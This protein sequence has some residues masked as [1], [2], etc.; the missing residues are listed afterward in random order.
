MPSFRSTLESVRLLYRGYRGYTGSI[1][2]LALL[3][4]ISGLLEAVGI[5]AFIPA[6]AFLTGTEGGSDIITGFIKDSFSFLNV[7]YSFR[8]LG[9]FAVILFFVRTLAL[10]WGNYI[11]AVITA[12]YE[13]R[14]REALFSKTIRS[15]WSYLLEQKIGHLQTILTTH[16]SFGQ[17]TLSMLG[18]GIILFM[19]VVAYM[20][21]AINISLSMSLMTLAAACVLSALISPLLSYTRRL[22]SGMEDISRDLSHFVNENVAGMKTVK[23]MHAEEPVLR[24]SNALFRS[25]RDLKI[26]ITLLNVLP[27]SLMQ[28]LGFLFVMALFYLSYKSGRFSLPSFMATVYLLQRI[29]LY[30]QQIQ[31]N[32]LSIS[33][34]NTYLRKLLAQEAEVARYEEERSGA[35]FSFE[36][37]LRFE[38]VHFSY[39]NRPEVLTG[40]SFSL[41]KSEM[42]GLIGPSG[43]G[44]TTVSDLLLR[45]FSPAQGLITLDGVPLHSLALPAW[46]KKVGYV[47]QDIF[48]LND[49]IAN[50]IRFYD[51][52]LTEKDLIAAAR[53]ANAVEFIDALPHGMETVIGEK[54]VTLSQGQR[55]R[56]VIARVLARKPQILIL[57]EA[58]SAL[59]NKSEAIIQEV[60][61]SLKSR[62]TILVIAHR[63]STVLNT[64][65]LLI[66]SD[67]VITEEGSPQE[68]LNDKD[69]YFFKN[70][71]K[72]F[73]TSHERAP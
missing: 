52:T 50:N 23:A 1:A 66:L 36:S 29:F 31:S 62:V 35:A 47:S 22:A 5:T 12:D 13:L 25:Y 65:R 67:G 64:D 38:N 15:S 57:D 8:F 55:Q 18:N 3:G 26:R 33:E 72:I 59:D 69:S 27:G 63:L 17:R 24:K 46:R 41:R 40:V 56:I 44:K 45:L 71:H 10:L 51:D 58:T 54:G 61:E 37:E 4:F 43:A 20:I 9:I 11:R 73:E 7:T 60:I 53:M 34:S 2:L 48:L 21:A 70:Y 49:T 68:L 16:V 30:V 14:M 42:V 6:F 28:P 19:S 39:P 32:A